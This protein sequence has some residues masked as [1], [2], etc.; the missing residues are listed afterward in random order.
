MKIYQKRNPDW[1]FEVLKQYSV[2]QKKGEKTRGYKFVTLW[3]QYIDEGMAQEDAYQKVE[4][5]FQEVE[6][7]LSAEL[8]ALHVKQLRTFSVPSINEWEAE[9]DKFAEQSIALQRTMWHARKNRSAEAEL[10]AQKAADE[11][12]VDEAGGEDP[13]SA[14]KGKKKPQPKAPK[15]K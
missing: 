7:K 6:S 13:A 11:P 14:A 8:D 10:L 5:Q 4:A 12:E 15:K 9:E 3:Q 1:S 2:A